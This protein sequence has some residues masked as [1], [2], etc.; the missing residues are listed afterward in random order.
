M[1]LDAAR[2]AR[3]KRHLTCHLFQKAQG[4]PRK[5]DNYDYCRTEDNI[6]AGSE[7]EKSQDRMFDMSSTASE[8]RRGGTDMYELSQKQSHLRAWDQAQLSRRAGAQT[9]IHHSFREELWY[10]CFAMFRHS[11]NK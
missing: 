4:C 1:T 3:V 11:V 2:S 10:G 9:S 6:A 7:V 8:V 5:Y